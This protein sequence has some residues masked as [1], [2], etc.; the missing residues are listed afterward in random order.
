[1]TNSRTIADGD[2]SLLAQDVS[3]I[4]DC[5]RADM[6][7]LTKAQKPIAN[8]FLEVEMQNDELPGH[9]PGLHSLNTSATEIG[10]KRQQLVLEALVAT[11][12]QADIADS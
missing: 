4:E 9:V 1:M 3:W 5:V 6:A 8:Q 11:T 10:A 7:T 2:Q 12:D